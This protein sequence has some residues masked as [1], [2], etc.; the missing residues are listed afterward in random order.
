M[1]PI[2]DKIRR[3]GGSITVLD[4]RLRIE[5]PPGTLSEQDRQ[6]LAQ[7]RQDLLRLFAPSIPVVDVKDATAFQPRKCAVETVECEDGKVRQAEAAA[8][9]WVEGLTPEAAAAAVETAVREWDALTGGHQQADR[10]PDQ[11]LDQDLDQQ[12]HHAG[13]LDQWLRENTVE[14]IECG[15]CGSLDQ[16]Q[17]IAGSWHCSR[18]DPLIKAAIIRERAARLRRRYA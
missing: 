3:S 13:D 10:Q 14:P 9:Q 5:A 16:W 2:L 17:S 1:I 7:H 11:D 18:C 15:K 4:G 6:V 8:I 12:Q